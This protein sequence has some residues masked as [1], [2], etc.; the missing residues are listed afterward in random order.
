MKLNFEK[1]SV[2]IREVSE[3]R[4]YWFIRTYYGEVFNDF[5]E[6]SYVGIGFN[7]IPY[8]LIKDA[9][10]T[11]GKNLL[12][13]YIENNTVYSGGEATKWTNQIIDFEHEVKTG[14]I[15]VIPSAN[16]DVLA[17]G[18][19]TSNV[20]IVDDK[21]TFE[22]RDKFEQYPEKRRT[23]SWL[24][25]FNRSV[26]GNEITNMFASRQAV[27]NIDNYAEVI[28]GQISSLFIKDGSA[29]LV[30]KIDQDQ[31]INAF[32]F[33]T[34]LDC[35]T[36]FYNEFCTEN[37]IEPN[38][39]LFLKIRVQS[40]GKLALKAFAISGILGVATIFA[41]SN[42]PKIKLELKKYG[43]FEGSGEGALKSISDFLDRREI[44]KQKMILFQD[45]LDQIKARRNLQPDLNHNVS[46]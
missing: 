17:I 22:F 14:D 10:S 42:D 9:N 31:E 4:K 20:K 23:V 46:N 30:I 8:Q 28:E 15:V 13:E 35:L 7:K 11:S 29:H 27:S 40:K 1:S 5:I 32:D 25:I 38:Q 18:E 6:N 3:T 41:L 26:L 39:N 21:R 2:D 43:T 16:S 44:R 34:F 33:S 12:K 36:F 19:V 37:G 24:N 45:S